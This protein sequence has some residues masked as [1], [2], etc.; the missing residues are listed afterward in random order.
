MDFAVLADHRVNLKENEKYLD[1]AREL[2]KLWN[3]KVMVA[4][5]VI[6]ALCPISKGLVQGLEDL[7]IRGGVEAIQTTEL[8]RSARIMRKVLGTC[9][10]NAS[11]RQS[12]DVKKS[13]GVKIIICVNH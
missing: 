12:A 4:P 2:K 13:H 3:M 5:M 1:F 7:E 6:G 10:L 11:E 9:H 8:L